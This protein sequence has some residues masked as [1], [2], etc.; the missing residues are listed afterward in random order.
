MLK[1]CPSSTSLTPMSFWFSKYSK[2]S[3]TSEVIFVVPYA[4]KNPSFLPS[5]W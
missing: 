2:Y 4:C 5:L 3:I 1:D